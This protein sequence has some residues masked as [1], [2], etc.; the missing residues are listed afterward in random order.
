[1]RGSTI[2]IR[3]FGDGLYATT[4]RGAH[5]P[6]HK[7]TQIYTGVGVG[8]VM[9]RQVPTI[10]TVQKTVEVIQLVPQEGIQERSAEQ[11]VDIPLHIS[12]RK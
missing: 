10:Q 8:V 1:M 4:E 6:C 5:R 11:V 3:V 2:R 7:K 12:W 9:Q